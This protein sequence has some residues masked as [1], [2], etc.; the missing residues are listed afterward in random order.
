MTQ[1]NESVAP[2]KRRGG[3]PRKE[4]DTGELKRLF[5]EGHSKRKIA[6]LMKRGYGS[7]HRALKALLPSDAIQNSGRRSKTQKNEF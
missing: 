7:V 2:R 4:I 6:R 3:R 1:S 5:A